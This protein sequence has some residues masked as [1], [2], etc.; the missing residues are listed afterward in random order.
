MQYVIS[1]PHFA[2]TR[3]KISERPRKSCSV[4][5]TMPRLRSNSYLVGFPRWNTSGIGPYSLYSNL[6]SSST[7]SLSSVSSARGSMGSKVGMRRIAPSKTISGYLGPHLSGFH[8]H[9]ESLHGCPCG[10]SHDSPRPNIESRSMPGALDDEA[11]E[12]SL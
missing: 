12:P 4:K 8:R 3:P 6:E 9:R 2:L 7:S 5:C 1:V 10:S 11:V